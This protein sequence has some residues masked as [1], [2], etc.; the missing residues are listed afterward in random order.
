MS[1]EYTTLLQGLET[2]CRPTTTQRNGVP[3][4]LEP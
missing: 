3:H 4:S 1:S 2:C